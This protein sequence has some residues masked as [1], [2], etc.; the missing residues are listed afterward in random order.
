MSPQELKTLILSDASATAFFNAGN[1]G[2]CAAYLRANYTEPRSYQITKLQLYLSFG[3]NRGL[4]I[5]QTLRTLGGP[6][7]P[8]P[9]QSA[10]FREI[11]DLLESQS[12]ERGPDLGLP[13]TATMLSE[14]VS[15]SIITSQERDTL[16]AL[17]KQPLSVTAAEV[18][19][20]RLR[21]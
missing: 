5:M 7:S 1:D 19:Y 8:V 3:F 15:G 11:V 4:A 12:A 18:E 13:E 14:W 21:I 2:G 17:G 6:S 9:E 20:A 16:L 10:V